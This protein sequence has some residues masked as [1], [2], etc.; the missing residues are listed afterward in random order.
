MFSKALGTVHKPT[1]LVQQ[2]LSMW[3]QYTVHPTM[4]V[5]GSKKPQPWNYYKPLDSQHVGN[6]GRAALLLRTSCWERFPMKP[7]IKRYC[8][9]SLCP[10]FI[11][12]YVISW[13]FPTAIDCVTVLS[14]S[15][16]NNKPH[17]IGENM[18]TQTTHKHFQLESNVLFGNNIE[19]ES[20]LLKLYSQSPFYILLCNVLFASVRKLLQRYYEDQFWVKVVQIEKLF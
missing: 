8:L 11:M 3:P 4:A 14:P 18:I 15:E 2:L 1:V 19:S 20:M 16:H 13:P 7:E 10:A 5:S 6:E 12:W 9:C 17:F